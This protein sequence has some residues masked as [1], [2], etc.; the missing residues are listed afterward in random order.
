MVKALSLTQ[1]AFRY[2]RLRLSSITKKIQQVGRL[3]VYLGAVLTMVSCATTLPN[4]PPLGESGVLLP[5]KVVWHDLVTPDIKSAKAFYGTLFDWSFEELSSGYVLASHNGRH[6][7]GIAKLDLPRTT[8]N[9]LPLL[10]VADIDQTLAEVTT[11]GGKTILQPFTLADRGRIAVLKDPQGA[12]FGIVQSSKGDPAD[13]K[14]EINDW[15]W[16]E[17]WTEDVPSAITFYQKVGKYH[18]AEKTFGD[19]RYRY[20]QSNGKPRIGVIE[21]PSPEIGNT[22]VAYI[23]VADV[24]ST[25]EKA[26]AL[27]GQVLMAPQESVRQ[28][29][30]AVLTDPNGAGFVVQEWDKYK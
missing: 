7:A 27:G 1:L 17:I 19:I 4:V 8:S 16:N 12:S 30:V 14:P 15:L 20:L 25:V 6:I 26:K 9:W 18:M 23:R 2:Q 13:R 21:K 22:W 10:S 29:T 3:A 28:G 11:A 24:N 5:G